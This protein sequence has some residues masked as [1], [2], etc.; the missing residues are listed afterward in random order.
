LKGIGRHYLEKNYAH[1]ISE[2]LLPTNFVETIINKDVDKLKVVNSSGEVFIDEEIANEIINHLSPFLNI[3][4]YFDPEKLRI[5]LE[6]EHLFIDDQPQICLGGI[7]IENLSPGQRCNALVPIILLE[8][9]NPLLIDQPE[10]NLD[11]KLVF[12]LVVDV[13][14]NLKE[15]RQIIVATHN[16]NIP[17]SGD[18]EQIITLEAISE[19][20]GR[21]LTHGSIDCTQ[22]IEQVKEIMEG[23]EKAFRIRAQ[24]Y[25]FKLSEYRPSILRMLN[26]IINGKRDWS[27]RITFPFRFL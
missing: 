13:L 19:S 22:I 23:G 5:L 17:V 27:P 21:V 12:D 6:L 9:R 26:D 16:P 4:K 7:P 1:L 20:K 24:K 14:R 18:A 25:G 11:N 2:K 15:Q 8:G 10:D 3:D